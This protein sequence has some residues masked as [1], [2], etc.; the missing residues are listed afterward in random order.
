MG[1]GEYLRWSTQT[2]RHS[3]CAAERKE[4]QQARTLSVD[5]SGAS[6]CRLPLSRKSSPNLPLPASMNA[7]AAAK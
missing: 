4:T 6:S 3:V 2:D 5:Y 7:T 1:F